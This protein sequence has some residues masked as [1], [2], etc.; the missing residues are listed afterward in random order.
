MSL[1]LRLNSYGLLQ[2]LWTIRY[3]NDYT[4]T[5][6][7]DVITQRNFVVDFI[8]LKLNFIQ[9]TQKSVLSHPLGDLG[10]T[11]ALHL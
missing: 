4:T 1:N 7:Q 3:G 6:S 5:Q 11:Y 10:A 2:Y 9:K 8:R